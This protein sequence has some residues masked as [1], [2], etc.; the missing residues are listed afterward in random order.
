MDLQFLLLLT[1]EDYPA[2]LG[3]RGMNARLNGELIGAEL[4]V[5]KMSHYQ[6]TMN[7]ERAQMAL[8]DDPTLDEPLTVE[9]GAEWDDS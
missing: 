4:H 7:L 1:D 6:N 8:A 2:A 9:G 5:Q 3:K